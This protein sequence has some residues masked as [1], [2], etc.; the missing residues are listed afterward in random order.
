MRET[1]STAGEGD[2][3]P[4]WAEAVMV[5]GR[6]SGS[7]RLAAATGAVGEAKAVEERRSFQ[8]GAG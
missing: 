3:G 5:A 8:G 6:D 4:D 1:K 2:D 7:E